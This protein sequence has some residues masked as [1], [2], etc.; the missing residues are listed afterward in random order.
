MRTKSEYL[1][2]VGV[3]FLIII[4]TY[5]FVS[6]LIR[7]RK[8]DLR[9]K[10]AFIYS[11]IIA[12]LLLINNINNLPLEFYSYDT[13]DTWIS[14]WTGNVL[15]EVLFGPVVMFFFIGMLIAAAEPFYRDQYPKQISFR[16]ILTAQ[17]IK[18]RSF[19]NSAIIGISL[20][21]AFFAFRTIFHLIEN[22][23]GG[24]TTTEVPKFD[25]L[26][27]YIPFVGV[28]LAGLSRAIRIE[29]IFRM[30]FIPF[31]Q[32][33]TKSTIFAVV[34]SSIIWGLQH[35]AHGFHQPFYM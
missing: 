18:S 6:I 32:K 30:F 17:G 4:I 8:K 15:L 26:S 22:K 27:T 3:S 35:A 31:L 28:L 7:A 13:K 5:L 34:A 33:Y 19:F 25:M 2:I 9:W 23:M 20:T 1:D 14:F 11:G 24:F 12:F 16:H 10:T 29:T 21:F